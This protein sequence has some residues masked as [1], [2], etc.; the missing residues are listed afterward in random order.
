MMSRLSAK[1]S[2][3][4]SLTLICLLSLPQ[5]ALAQ[6]KRTKLSPTQAFCTGNLP[7]VPTY[8]NDNSR[9]GVN[10]NET[11]LSP[12]TNFA[13]L[14]AKTVVTDGLIY[15]QPLYIHG[16]K[17]SNG[18]VGVCHGATNVVFVAT[19]NNTVY[20]INA[21]SGRK[22]WHTTLDPTEKAIPYFSIK[23]PNGGPCTEITPQEGIASTPVIDTSV[24]P[25]ILYTLTRHQVKGSGG[26]TYRQLLHAI[27][28]TTGLEVVP[29]VDIASV[30]GTGFNPLVERQRP[31]LA[32]YNPS[33]GLANVYITWGSHCDSN[34]S[35]IYDGWV[36]EFQLNYQNLGTGFASLGSFTTEPLGNKRYGGIWMSGAAPGVDSNGNLYLSVG[37][38]SVTPPS[39]QSGQWGE[40][41]LKLQSGTSPTQGPQVVDFYTPN[42]YYGLNAGKRNA[43]F[44]SGPPCPNGDLLPISGDTDVGATGVVLMPSLATP[45]L[46]AIGKQGMLYIIPYS[47]SSNNTMGGLDGPTGG[48]T[49]TKGADAGS[50]DCSTSTTLPTPGFIAQCFPAIP[51]DPNKGDFN[52]LRTSP[53]FWSA[54]QN[55]L[56]FMG[57]LRDVLRGYS[58]NGTTFNTTAYTPSTSHAV[59]FPYPGA[60]ISVSWNGTD[61]NTGVVWAL[62]TA[63]AG[64]IQYANGKATFVASKPPVLYAFQA[65]PNTQGQLTYLWDSTLLPNSTTVMPG[66]VK[67]VVPTIAGGRIYIAGGVPNYFG[68]GTKGCASGTKSKCAGQ[69]TILH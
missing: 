39:M 1:V 5:S 4:L 67:F 18:N 38:G 61:P 6:V 42:D 29:A 11:V 13:N 35:G 64:N 7:C 46:T 25:P 55:Q 30:L 14:T 65:V 60:S 49:G 16:L 69:L 10:P 68:V 28:T 59:N 52:G 27:D 53:A 51:F 33:S 54:G 66:S 17:D 48:Y 44:G 58:L 34:F 63:G 20:G 21:V 41:V 3:S 24:N 9:D 43:C 15:T 26:P 12:T 40:S 31:G 62:S 19:E 23:A 22:C 50:T 32:L 36:A 2:V 8:H 57:G 56:L 47:A 45:E 37:N